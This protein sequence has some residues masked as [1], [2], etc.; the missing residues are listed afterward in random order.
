MLVRSGLDQTVLRQVRLLS[1]PLA[2]V[3][4]P[5]PSSH[6][7]GPFFLQIWEL[8]SDHTNVLNAERFAIALRLVGLAQ[9]G[10]PLDRALAATGGD[11]PLPTIAGA[12]AASVPPQPHAPAAVGAAAAAGPADTDP[13]FVVSP[14]DR[15]RHLQTMQ[16][17]QPVNGR[18]P[19]TQSRRP[20]NDRPSGCDP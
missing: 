7:S 12:S 2:E 10:R 3:I 8:A 18:V 15:D 16:S 17:C 1:H 11:L 14:A 6:P 5:Q 9:A 4:L 13:A 20:A 19:G